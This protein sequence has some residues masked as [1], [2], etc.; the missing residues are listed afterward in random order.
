V[1]AIMTWGFGRNRNRNFAPDNEPLDGKE[2]RLRIEIVG[3]LD[4]EVV[5]YLPLDF[6]LKIHPHELDLL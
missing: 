3:K 4:S 2:F 6:G 5:L 1:N